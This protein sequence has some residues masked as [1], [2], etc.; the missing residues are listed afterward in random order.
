MAVERKNCIKLTLVTTRHFA[1]IEE[2]LAKSITELRQVKE[3]KLRR[4]LL[5]EL[6]LLLAEANRAL[7][8]TTSQTPATQY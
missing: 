6:R 5:P 2:D 7:L 4:Q 3:P 1:E 8:E